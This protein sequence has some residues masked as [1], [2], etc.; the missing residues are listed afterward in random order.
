MA[1][2]NLDRDMYWSP[3]QQVDYTLDATGNAFN[4]TT[5]RAN[6]NGTEWSIQGT[7]QFRDTIAAAND[8]HSGGTILRPPPEENAVYKIKG[9]S[10]SST[11]WWGFFLT[12]DTGNLRTG[13]PS[14]CVRS[15]NVNELICVRYDPLAPTGSIVFFGA[16]A[17][18]VS[19][20]ILTVSAQRLVSKPESYVSA[21][22]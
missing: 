13:T 14:F 8:F 6:T 2:I 3:S 1:Q 9:S 11:T 18:N 4:A 19:N 12:N 21:V 15:Q 22:A 5:W 16:V 10:S 17:G 20:P 7:T